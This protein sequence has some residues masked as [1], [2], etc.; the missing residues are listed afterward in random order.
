MSRTE[1]ADFLGQNRTF[2][3]EA[4]KYFDGLLKY[5]DKQIDQIAEI[6]NQIVNQGELPTEFIGQIL[7][8]SEMDDRGCK[9]ITYQSRNT[10]VLLYCNY[11]AG[12]IYVEFFN[13]IPWFGKRTS[14]SIKLGYRG[15]TGSN[16]RSI[17][18]FLD[19]AP[20]GWENV[21]NLLIGKLL[22]SS[23]TEEALQARDCF[24][25]IT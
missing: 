23:I 10:K 5:M 3:I 11:P 2:F 17:G 25:E 14:F 7:K 16:P 13:L 18:S 12:F 1:Y 21:G 6:E 15:L 19:N 22:A 24:M 20:L 8:S 4:Q 9:H